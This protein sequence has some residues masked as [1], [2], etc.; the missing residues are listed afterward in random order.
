MLVLL[1]KVLIRAIRI[2][3]DKLPIDSIIKSI[4]VQITTIKSHQLSSSKNFRNK[5]SWF[6]RLWRGKL[7]KI[8]SF[9]ESLTAIDGIEQELITT[10]ASSNCGLECK[11]CFRI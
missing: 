7:T 8:S 11:G 4:G 3:T 10:N 1:A 6:L 2:K 9:V 5:R